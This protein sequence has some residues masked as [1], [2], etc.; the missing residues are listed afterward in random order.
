MILPDVNVLIGAFRRD[1]PQHRVCR[2]WLDGAVSGD[3]RF[4]ISPLV[5]AAVVRITTNHRAFKVP[6]TVDDAFG[7]SSRVAR[8]E[9]TIGATIGSTCLM[10][11]AV[12]LGCGWPSASFAAT[13]SVCEPKT[14]FTIF[15]PS[16]VSILERSV[17]ASTWGVSAFSSDADP[18]DVEALAEPAYTGAA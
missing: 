15:A 18:E 16:A 13:S 2:S 11:S 3:A 9:S 4:G 1:A 5:L 10:M 12:T 14:F 6:S 7:F 17:V 8:N